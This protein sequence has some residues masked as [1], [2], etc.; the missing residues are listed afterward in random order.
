MVLHE[1]KQYACHLLENGSEKQDDNACLKKWREKVR[2]HF[3][4][5]LSRW[6]KKKCKKTI[7]IPV[8]LK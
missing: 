2:I 8:D 7:S 4:N 1:A 6:T 5:I 3:E